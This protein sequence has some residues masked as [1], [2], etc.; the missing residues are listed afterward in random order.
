MN[1]AS[2][3]S[4]TLLL[5][6]APLCVLAESAHEPWVST[7]R[8]DGHGH[9][10][11]H[12]VYFAEHTCMSIDS[13]QEGAP[14][15]IDPPRLSPTV[16]VVLNRGEGGQCQPKLRRL[17]HRITITDWPR[18]LAVEVFYVDR[19][20]VFVQ[21]SRPPIERPGEIEAEIE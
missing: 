8:A 16:T 14:P 4:R 18:A 1:P 6:I 7:A 21:S 10:A 3:L 2:T 20:G 12:L 13:V 15:S 17:E 9:I 5:A 11:L 19:H